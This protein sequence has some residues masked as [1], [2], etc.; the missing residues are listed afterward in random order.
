M[1]KDISEFILIARSLK[2]YL[3]H[4]KR[5]KEKTNIKIHNS[6]RLTFV[7]A[8]ALASASYR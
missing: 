5:I 3:Y 4:Q 2:F 6:I 8:F 7:N 1:S